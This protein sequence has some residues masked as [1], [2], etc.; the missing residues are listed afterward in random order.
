MINTKKESNKDF[1]RYENKAIRPLMKELGVSH[2]IFYNPIFDLHRAVLSD[3][4][5]TVT[6]EHLKKLNIPIKDFYKINSSG[7]R[8]DE[9]KSDHEGLHVLFAGCS[10]TFGDGMF[11]EHLW[12]HKL[13]RMIDQASQT[14]GYFNIGF[15]GADPL[16][17]FSQIIL[18]IEKFGNPDVIFINI[19]DTPRNPEL[20]KTSEDINGNKKVIFHSAEYL[21]L[22][23]QTLLAS[24]CSSNNIEL[25]CFSYDKASNIN[26]P[27]DDYRAHWKNYYKFTEDEMHAHMFNYEQKNKYHGFKDF[28][29]YALDDFHPGISH[30]DFYYSFISDI[31]KRNTSI[32]KYD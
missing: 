15:P 8:S 28:F 2:E 10:N 26:L 20:A 30:Q 3:L 13:Y 9:F 16:Q 31:F 19:P 4:S 1:F 17:I 32:I 27:D 14:S 24:Y 5:V 6:I 12:S 7:L 25:Y 11:L 18:Y 23:F 22:R 29:E 21:M